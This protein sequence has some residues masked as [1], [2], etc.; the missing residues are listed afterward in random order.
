M[1]VVWWRRT[2]FSRPWVK[3]TC[4]ARALPGLQ[5]HV[6]ET[7]NACTALADNTQLTETCDQHAPV[8]EHWLCPV[9]L[10]LSLATTLNV[11]AYCSTG[12]HLWLSVCCHRN[13]DHRKRPRFSEV[14]ASLS[15]P[16]ILPTSFGEELD[17]ESVP[18]AAL[19]LGSPLEAAKS[20]YLDL[21]HTY[22]KTK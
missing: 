12:S 15:R 8:S 6:H 21:Q 19:V 14:F 11:I 2:N 17:V 9:K 20:L 7:G 13:P 4:F 1:G 18:P 5:S 3:T 16:E 22:R 10:S